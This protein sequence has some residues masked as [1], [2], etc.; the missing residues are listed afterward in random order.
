[1]SKY[2]VEFFAGNEADA[3]C[4]RIRD[5]STDAVVFRTSDLGQSGRDEVDTALEDFQILEQ[6]EVYECFYNQM[7][8]FDS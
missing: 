1:M 3:P 2:A 7:C 6:G 5:T 4:Y 8:E